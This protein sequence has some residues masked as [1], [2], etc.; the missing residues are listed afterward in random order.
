MKEY[1]N[2][3]KVKINKKHIDIRYCINC[4]LSKACSIRDNLD[5][6]FIIEF[7]DIGYTLLYENE[8]SGCTLM[9]THLLPAMKWIRME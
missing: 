1:K 8:K 4:S 9:S 7:A 6:I 5:A 2:G 3:D